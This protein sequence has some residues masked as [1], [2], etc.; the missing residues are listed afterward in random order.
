[1]PPFRTSAKKLTRRSPLRLRACWQWCANGCNNSQ[2]VWDLQCI[3][4]RIQLISQQRWKS[5]ANG[6]N[7][8]AL[9]VGDHGTIEML[10]VVG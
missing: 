1:M 7:I 9:R 2:Q 3:V 10:G 8:V 4:G 5:C 6:S